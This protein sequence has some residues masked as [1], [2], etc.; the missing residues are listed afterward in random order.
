[1]KCCVYVPPRGRPNSA[2]E[3]CGLQAELGHKA[4]ATT[5]QGQVQLGAPKGSRLNAVLRLGHCRNLQARMSQYI[6]GLARA[7]RTAVRCPVRV[8]AP[9]NVCFAP[10]HPCAT[11]CAA[12]RHRSLCRC[13]R[14]GAVGHIATLFGRG[15]ARVRP[16]RALHGVS[17]EERLG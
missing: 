3:I 4:M 5:T 7:A 6:A 1:M 17:V 11:H 13:P 15:R 8:A 9:C 2:T 16:G 12:R 10:G 14:C